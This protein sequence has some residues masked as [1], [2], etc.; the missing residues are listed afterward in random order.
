M[1]LWLWLWRDAAAQIQP[2]AQEFPYATGV[3]RKERKE[4]RRKGAREG[5]RKEGR[6]N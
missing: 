6:I 2:L 5:G 1:L 3:A 4:G